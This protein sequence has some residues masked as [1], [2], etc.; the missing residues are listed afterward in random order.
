L[1][2]TAEKA[3]KEKQAQKQ[4]EMERKYKRQEKQAKWEKELCLGLDK[5]IYLP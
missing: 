5:H 3:P 4:A 2:G 1:N